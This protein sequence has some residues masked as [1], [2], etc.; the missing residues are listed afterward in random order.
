MRR[1]ILSSLAIF[2]LVSSCDP[3]GSAARTTGQ[4]ATEADSGQGPEHGEPVN[5]GAGETWT[6][7][8]RDLLGPGGAADCSGTH[9][10]HEDPSAPGALGSRG[11]VCAS[12]GGCRDSLLSP[13]TRL[14]QPDDFLA[15]DGSALMKSL[16]RLGPKGGTVGSMPKQSSYVF[17]GGALTRIKTWIRN[18]A[19]DD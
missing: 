11:F 2:S 19:P 6:D 9:G 1:V 15:P 14:V 10:C 5:E 8:Y 7:L 13:E 18:R 12:Q 17:T 16:R 3:Y 4:R